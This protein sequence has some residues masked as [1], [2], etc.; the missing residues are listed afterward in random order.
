M[1]DGHKWTDKELKKLERRISREYKQ[2]EREV[3]AK[4]DDYLRR[5]EIK[6]KIKRQALEDGKIT[7]QEY[8]KWRT[9][10]IMIGKR[11]EEMKNTLA[12]DFHNANKIVASMTREFSYDAYA[13]NHNY[14]TFEVE[15][16]SLVD[17]S[18]TLYDRNTVER[19]VRDNPDMLPPPGKKVSQRIKEGKDVLWNKQQIQSVMT[20]SILQGEPIPSIAKRLATAVGDSNMKAATRNARTMTTGAENAGRVDSYKRA[21]RLG[22]KMQQMW[23]AILD[24]RTRHEHRQLD[25]QRVDVG[26]KFHVEGYEIEFPGDPHAAAEMVYNCRCTLIAVIPGTE[27][28]R[29]KNAGDLPRNSKLGDMSY[30][31]W[32][33]EQLD[34]K[35]TIFTPTLI[36]SI[37]GYTAMGGEQAKNFP[38]TSS[39]RNNL[40]KAASENTLETTTNVYR[41]IDL[42]SLEYQKLFD[43][44]Y[45]NGTI[46]VDFDKLQ[47]F[48]KDKKRAF[49]FGGTSQDYILYKIPAGTKINGIDIQN[50]SIYPE[51]QEILLGENKFTTSYDDIDW[52][53]DNH[54]ILTLR[55]IKKSKS[56]KQ[57]YNAEYRKLSR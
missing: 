41:K 17:T 30:E 46:D 22:I 44:I 37:H 36:D 35:E 1:D 4:L 50:Y 12:Q 11:W 16:G 23:I 29:I 55:P 56:I 21:K 45:E 43:K 33:N 42:S 2:A 52:T 26:K 40:Y 27:I 24:G 3:Q 5:F 49:T 38:F 20:Q 7:K 47:S 25:G 54:L 8:I 9:G 57:A 51:E 53:S 15:K 32:K 10:Q 6:D 48:T 19:L 14:G 39:M 18:Y 34:K 28:D 13:L 31:E